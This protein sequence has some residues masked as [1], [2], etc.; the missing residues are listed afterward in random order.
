MFL[1]YLSCPIPYL[2]FHAAIF[3]SKKRMWHTPYKGTH[4]VIIQVFWRYF[5]STNWLINT[6]SEAIFDYIWKNNMLVKKIKWLNDV[7]KFAQGSNDWRKI[8]MLK[9]QYI[10]CISKFRRT[11]TN[12]DHYIK[13]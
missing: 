5:R 11:K 3:N 9:E 6:L 10:N 13:I 8:S 1:Q 7:R 2:N 12:K 4:N